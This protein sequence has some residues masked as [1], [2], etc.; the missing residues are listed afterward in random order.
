VEKVDKGL[1]TALPLPAD[2]LATAIPERL[3]AKDR[4]LVRNITEPYFYRITVKWYNSFQ[5]MKEFELLY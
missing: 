4:A 5:R 3:P 1:Q 2:D